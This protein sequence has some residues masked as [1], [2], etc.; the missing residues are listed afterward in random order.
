MWPLNIFGFRRQSSSDIRNLHLYLAETNI[1][2][3]YKIS[4][5]LNKKQ[6]QQTICFQLDFNDLMLHKRKYKKNLGG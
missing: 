5:I 4:L 3:I 2:L 6:K 1:V